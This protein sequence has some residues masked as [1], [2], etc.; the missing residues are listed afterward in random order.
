MVQGLAPLADGSA[1]DFG[2]LM[3]RKVSGSSGSQP[4]T[5][6]TNIHRWLQSLSV[7]A[8]PRAA[9]GYLSLLSV[10]STRWSIAF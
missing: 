7:L 8:R 2:L 1:S 5:K 6:L 10:A 4:T 3:M 9:E